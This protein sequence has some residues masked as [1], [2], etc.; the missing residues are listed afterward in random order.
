MEIIWPVSKSLNL[1]NSSRMQS[2]D[3]K[4]WILRILLVYASLSLFDAVIDVVKP[5]NDVLSLVAYNPELA[6][7]P[8]RF[9]YLLNKITDKEEQEDA[10]RYGVAALV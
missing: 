8:E 4:V 7:L 5:G 10:V 1:L 2:D 6:S 3:V 9:V